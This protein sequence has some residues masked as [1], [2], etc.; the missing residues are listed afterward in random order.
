M[1]TKETCDLCNLDITGAPVVHDI[2]GKHHF[3]CQGCARIYQAASENGMLDQVLV[4]AP[5]TG[6]QKEPILPAGESAYFSIQGMWCAGC[7]VAAE[8]VLCKLP[9]VTDANVSFAAE[10][11]RIYYDAQAVAPEQM[12]KTLDALGYQAQMLNDPGEQKET[13]QQQR[14][15][16]QLITAAA[17]G[18][19]VM[20]LYLTQLYHQYAAGEFDLPE[21]R[22]LQYLAWGLATPVLFYGGSSF[23]RGAWR[24][25]RARTATMD[26]LVSLGV[27]SAY[28]YSIFISVR[29]GGE[30][31]FDSVVM[32]TTFVMLGRWLETLGGRQAR[33]G[34]SQ[35]LSLQPQQAW[36]QSAD[37]WL[38]TSADS[39]QTGDRI[40]VKPG[41]RVPADAK[42]LEGRA[43]LDEALLTGEY[44]PVEK[45]PDDIVFAGS[46][47]TD[48][49]IVCQVE[50]PVQQTRLAQLTRLVEQTLADKPPLQR[51]ADR[52]AA[53]FAGGILLTSV[54]TAGGWYL[55]TGSAARAIINGVAVLVVA[56]PCALGL[57]TPL[58]LTVALGRSVERGLLVRNPAVLE[59]AGKSARVV[60]DKTGTLTQGQLS[61]IA[62]VPL[63]GSGLSP[64]GLLHLAATAEQYSEHPLAAAI[65][66]AAGRPLDTHTSEQAPRVADF[67]ALPGLGVTSQVGGHRLLVGSLLLFE[68]DSI[69]VDLRPL[70][71]S[72]AG[73]GESVVW[74]GRDDRLLGF[75]ALRDRLNPEAV[76]VL[77]KL[78]SQGLRVAMLSG[79]NLE[80]TKAIAAELELDDFGGQCL[81]AEKASRI[82]AW[83]QQGERVLMVGDGVNDAPALAQADWSITVTGGA[84]IAGEMSD[85]IMVNS[86]L[87]LIP[88]FIRFSQ[89]TRQII[90]QNL[91]WAFAYNLVAVPL[92]AFGLISPVIAAVAMAGSSLLVVTN[93]LR[94]R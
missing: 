68:N 9:G 73:R 58:A 66:A 47:A 31:Y 51:I 54:L 22:Q 92:A 42:I 12:L 77:R 52:A 80:T 64:E 21:V 23:L 34:I 15:L 29:G 69:P 71:E 3:C 20:L 4:S 2:G 46:V 18:M 7:A 84:D 59:Q 90:N 49:A 93:S 74:V 53:W 91:W 65:V 40:L 55:T 88:W 79:D 85:L 10:R 8:N 41:E 25:I 14:T 26:T 6:V 82:K 70:A 11:G 39:L 72:H 60:F 62:A 19:Q 5:G 30:V 13:R 56:C 1:V 86:D 67:K 37:G 78:R 27:V 16:L 87:M 48:A 28:S 50:R 83:Q 45:E 32:I 35:L 63:P 17:F 61:V 24:A 38:Q 94:L 81:P 36:R 43:A 44:L 76:S 75:I 57:A 33:K 89:R